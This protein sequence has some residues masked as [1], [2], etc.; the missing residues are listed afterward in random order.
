MKRL[1]TTLA[2]VALAAVLAACSG[3]SAAPTPAPSVDP[4]AL[5]IS[6]K[7]L[8]FSTDKLVCTEVVYQAYQGPIR[9]PLVEIMGRRTLPALEIVK[10]WDEGRGK[11]EAPFD[12][13][14]FLD[15]DEVTGTA[16]EVGE[17]ELTE[18]IGRSGLTL[19]QEDQAGRP[20]LMSPWVAALAAASALAFLLFPRRPPGPVS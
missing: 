20:L 11:P 14:A 19:L 4:D 1:A 13:V 6:S 5:R 3:T 9:F 17:A 18:S 7:D 16:R 8:K 2:L 12:F 10:M 15:G